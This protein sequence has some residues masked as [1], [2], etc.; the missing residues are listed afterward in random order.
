MFFSCF[1]KFSYDRFLLQS[2]Q[3]ELYRKIC[4]APLKFPQP[5][6]INSAQGT[7]TTTPVSDAA[8]NILLRFLEKDPNKRLG[9]RHPP[10]GLNDIKQHSF[11]Y[12]FIDWDALESK[13]I[14]PPFVPEKDEEYFEKMFT[15]KPIELTPPERDSRYKSKHQDELF[16]DFN[17]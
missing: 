3:N 17:K 11:F 4:Q 9:A 12:A 13:K 15:D 16:K 6:P 1:F 10:E 5:R 2:S 14:P 8:K 7:R